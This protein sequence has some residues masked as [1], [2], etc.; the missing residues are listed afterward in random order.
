MKQT[1]S[2]KNIPNC[3]KTCEALFSTYPTYECYICL[4]C[5]EGQ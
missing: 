4:G 2:I 3:D 1:H 5:I